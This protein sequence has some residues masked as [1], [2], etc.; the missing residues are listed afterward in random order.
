MLAAQA[1]LADVM[2]TPATDVSMLVAAV[3]LPSAP[4]EIDFDALS[5]GAV[6]RRADVGERGLPRLQP[7][8]RGGREGEHAR[9]ADIRF[10][11]GFAENYLGPIFAPPDERPEKVSPDSFVLPYRPGRAFGALG[12]H[13]RRHRRVRLPFGNNRRSAT[14]PS[15][16]PRSPRARFRLADATRTIQNRVPQFAEDVRQARL[17]WQQR[18]ASVTGYEARGRDA[19]FARRGR[20]H[21]Y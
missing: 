1:L 8:F 13:R 16:S 19:A 6:S 5:K 20:D 21:A 14:L 3:A 10:S 17:E 2:G 7:D 18:Q 11:G 4:I 9:A 15:P 12:A